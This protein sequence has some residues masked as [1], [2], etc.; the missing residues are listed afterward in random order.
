MRDMVVLVTG[1]AG[2]VGRGICTTVAAAGAH[3]VLTGS[4][5]EAELMAVAESLPGQKHLGVQVSMDATATIGEL[6][7]AVQKRYGRLDVLVNNAATTRLVPFEDLDDL[8]DELI[9]RIFRVNWRGAFA[10]VRAFRELLSVSGH[11]LVVNISSNAALTGVGSNIA[12]C[13]SKAALDS[14]T[15]SLARAL[16]PRIRVI[17]LAPGFVDTGFVTDDPAW[18]ARAARQSLFQTAIDPAEIGQAVVALA[19]SF[20]KTTGVFIPVDGGRL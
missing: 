16:A 11:G 5:P 7:K 15:R 1:G 6:A 19:T 9:D 14:M 13:A 8:D 17:S 12:Y 4:R 3:V 10:F 20:P 2:G 18:R